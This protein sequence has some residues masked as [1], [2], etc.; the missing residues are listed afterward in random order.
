MT[1]ARAT[2]AAV[3][4]AA[5]LL[6]LSACTSS[7]GDNGST[8]APPV[9]TAPV[10]ESPLPSDTASVTTSP[11]R[12]SPAPS[13][14]APRSST[15][16]PSTATTTKAPPTRPVTPAC[17]AAS[18]K[19]DALRGGAAPGTEIAVLTFTNISATTCTISGFPGLTLLRN[20]RVIGTPAR[21]ALKTPRLVTLKPKAT[22]ESQI[23]DFISCQAPLSDTG[24]VTPPGTTTSVDVRLEL[25]AC[26][27]VVD[28]VRP[29]E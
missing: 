2:R 19:V 3:L 4:L 11:A 26:T 15:A 16:A 13:T 7:G 18:L 28:P 10:S 1:P 5:G 22:A 6:G 24:R 27:V 23:T 21:A 20:G 25:R 9:T 12:S 17:A 14:S 29:G 8:S